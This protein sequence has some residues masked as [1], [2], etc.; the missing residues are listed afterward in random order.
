VASAAE[1]DD[2]WERF[3]RGT[4]RFNEGADKYFIGP[5]AK[6]WDFVMPD[7]VELALGRFF[8]NARFPIRFVNDLLQEK[9][10]WA[11]EDFGRFAIN[12]SIGLAGFFDPASK[13]GLMGHDED[14]GQTLGHW[15]V[16]PGPY[17]VLPI[18]GPS[19][20]RHTVG[21]VA[22]SAAAVYPF[23]VPFWGSML[24]TTTDR[25]NYRSQIDETLTAER[26]NALDFYV[27]VRNAY[28]QNRENKVNDR[29]DDESGDD[30]LYD[31]DL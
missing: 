29:E 19:S 20:P 5:V 3:N 13:L 6:G 26:E 27:F 12:T 18:L 7:E 28:T 23:F 14:F 22:D 9:L 25:L 31:D 8:D 15:G 10:V 1:G 2:P 11:V 16:P 17:L 30:D 24:A 4:F 21:R